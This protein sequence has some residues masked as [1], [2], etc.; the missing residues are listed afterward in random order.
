MSQAYSLKD[1]KP[2][3]VIAKFASPNVRPGA[4]RVPSGVRTC[5]EPFDKRWRRLPVLVAF[6]RFSLLLQSHIGQGT[7]VVRADTLVWNRYSMPKM[8]DS[9]EKPSP[10]SNATYHG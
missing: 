5:S 1:L 7:L 4:G 6:K 9:N 10:S 3:Q 2:L 8:S